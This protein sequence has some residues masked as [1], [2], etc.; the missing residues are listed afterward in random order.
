M[1]GEKMARKSGITRC[2]GNSFRY[3]Y[4]TCMVE[5]VFKAT[6]ENRKDNEEWLQKYNEPLW[7]IDDKGYIVLERIGLR[8]ENWK[9]KEARMEYLQ[10][11]SYELNAECSALVADFVKYELPYYA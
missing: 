6:E 11:W 2:K 8:P 3:D 4:D 7:N 10:E 9:N 5:Y 1:D